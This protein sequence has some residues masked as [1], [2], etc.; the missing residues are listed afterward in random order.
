MSAELS[1]AQKSIHRI[2]GLNIAMGV[3]LSLIH[4]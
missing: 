2:G 3:V 4:I 1:R